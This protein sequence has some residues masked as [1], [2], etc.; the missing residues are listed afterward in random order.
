[1]DLGY[2]YVTRFT[3][4]MFRTPR[5]YKSVFFALVA[6]GIAGLSAFGEGFIA[7][8]EGVLYIGVPALVAAFVTPP[9]DKYLGGQ[10]NWNR[11]GFLAV[12]CGSISIVF[13]V[14]AALFQ[15]Y[16]GFDNFVY[17]ALVAS[18]SLIFGL[19]ILVLLAISSDSIPRTILPASLQ[20]VVGAGVLYIYTGLF[21]PLSGSYFVN[22][23]ATCIL[24]IGGAYVFVRLV[25]HPV[26]TSIG[27]SGLEL[28]RG[29]I[30]YITDGTHELEEVL[31]RMGESVV[32][33]LTVL[34]F[35]NIDRNKERARFVLPMV[36]PGIMGDIGGGNL[37]LRLS[38]SSPS[39]CFIPH[40]TADHDFNPVGQKEVEKI[41]KAIDDAIDSIE[42][43]STAS[44]SYRLQCGDTK[45]LG[46]K[47]GKGA[48]LITTF[49]PKSSDDIRFSVGL[50]AL[51]EAKGKGINDVMLV[52]AH[53]CCTAN[54]GAIVSPGSERSYNIVDCSG[55]LSD[56]LLEEKSY[57][58]KL[59]ISHNS[60]KW[61]EEQGMGPLG[62]RVSVLEVNDQ[63]TAYVLIDGNNMVPR[64]RDEIRKKI[65]D[66]LGVDEAEIMTTDT[67]VVNKVNS[68]NMIGEHIPSDELKNLIVSLVEEAIGDLEPVKCGTVSDKVEIIVFG[69]DRIERLATT[70]NAVASIGTALAVMT[71]F[72]ALLLSALIF[73]LN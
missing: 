7:A 5:W 45:M 52:D 54:S 41:R 31:E 55:K 39:L 65:I 17:D 26:K 8:W 66:D 15:K 30:G 46:Q 57:D 42:Y 12:F 73:F 1:M 3:R 38:E 47:F 24:Y 36:H 29:F 51:T 60:T 35:K 33:P 10:M 56:I 4:Y 37:P 25:D 22:L 23:I 63:K 59:G 27:V 70:L 44:K 19:R 18:L 14:A 58:L 69:N 20:T 28:L 40:A 13:V 67:H 2:G 49:S 62:V 68:H 61:S 48:L 9:I 21:D 11:S 71:T 50:N 32:V 72:A 6:G 64:L 34:S 43:S 53:N 16:L